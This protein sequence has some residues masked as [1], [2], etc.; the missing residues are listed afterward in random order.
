MGG[1]KV[2]YHQVL[3]K[4]RLLCKKKN[5]LTIL[6]QFFKVFVVVLED[7]TLC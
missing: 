7:T 6:N 1:E 4:Y 5:I 3:I 2:I